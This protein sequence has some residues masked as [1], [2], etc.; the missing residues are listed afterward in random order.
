[1][2][3]LFYRSYYKYF[4]WNKGLVEY[5][6]S[7]KKSPENIKLYVDTD[8]LAG[9]GREMN[10]GD[11][12]ADENFVEDFMES[13]ESFC[14]YYNKYDNTYKCPLPLEVSLK[15]KDSNDV[16]KRVSC[17]NAE[18]LKECTCKKKDCIPM[19]CFK[20]EAEDCN[21]CKKNVFDFA[22][23]DFLAIA[24]HIACKTCN[25]CKNADGPNEEK[26]RAAGLPY[27][28]KYCSSSGKIE[29]KKMLKGKR[30]SLI[31]RFLQ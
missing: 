3:S 17:S 15:Q 4:L 5:Y 10:V 11:Y 19:Q 13:V 21:G 12:S 20:R 31:C 29:I 6:L 23:P 26:C 14:N 8:I 25:E 24:K 28:I 18:K 16:T 9:I 22:R 1:M 30:I 7:D 2:E 27:Y